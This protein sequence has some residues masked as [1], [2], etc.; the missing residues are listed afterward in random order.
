MNA[1]LVSGPAV[2]LL[3]PE[4]EVSDPDALAGR[5]LAVVQSRVTK[6]VGPCGMSEC[7]GTILEV[8]VPVQDPNTSER[9]LHRHHCCSQS[10]CRCTCA[11]MD[12]DEARALLDR[13]GYP[14]N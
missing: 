2:L 5:R 13:I 9:S 12:P 3:G 14:W 8:S 4:Q 7:P 11:M 10:G 6:R 1:D